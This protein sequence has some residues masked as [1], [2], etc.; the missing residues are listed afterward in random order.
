MPLARAVAYVGSLPR[1]LATFE[2][3]G[4]TMTNKTSTRRSF[5]ATAGALA[6]G[7]AATHVARAFADEDVELAEDPA[8][9]AEDLEPVEDEE[10]FPPED[11][12]VW[13]SPEEAANLDVV[14]EDGDDLE[15]PLEYFP[16]IELEEDSPYLDLDEDEAAIVGADVMFN[17]VPDVD[18][19]NAVLEDI[20][21]NALKSL[22]KTAW[23][24]AMNYGKSSSWTSCSAQ[25]TPPRKSSPSSMRFKT[26]LT[27]WMRRCALSTSFSKRTSSRGKSTIS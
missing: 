18:G 10:W 23:N 9:P 5:V 16:P 1:V 13:L 8:E 17:Y 6:L 26:S 20:V 27:R 25:T 7:A 24:T 11:E 21:F 19:L 3:R 14:R 2:E 22:G 12:E 4:H 15:D